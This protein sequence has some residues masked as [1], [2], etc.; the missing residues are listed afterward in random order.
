MKKVL[1]LV[2][3]KYHP[4]LSCGE[5]LKRSL[6][7]TG[8]FKVE[9]TEDNGRL[10]E[11]SG[12]DA[13]ALY[14]AFGELARDTEKAFLAYVRSGGGVLA[15]HGA[16]YSFLESPGYVEMIGTQFTGHGPV[17]AFDVELAPDAGSI[18]TRVSPRFPVVDEFYQIDRR[19][20]ARLRPMLYGWWQFEKK[21][22]GY[23]RDYGKGRVF[24][25]ALGHDERVFRHA[26]FQNLL[27]KGLRYVTRQKERTVRVG[28]LGYGPAFKMGQHH[29]SQIAA[30]PGLTLTAVCDRDPARL[31][32][33]REEQGKGIATFR[34]A[35]AM[36]ASGKVD[37]GVVILP[38][39][40][41]FEGAKTLLEA[42]LHVITEKPFAVHVSE[43]EAL[44]GLARKRGV[45]LSVYHNR[46]WDPEIRT[47]AEVISSGAIGQ[48]FSI[49]CQMCGFGRPGQAWRSHK[50]IS[51]G[52]AYD[53]GAHQFEKI[54]QLV[55]WTD[56]SGK[57]INR[58]AF[59][60]GHFLKKRW[61]DTTN[62][63]FVRAY[64]RFDSGLEAQLLVSSLCAS[65]KPLWCLLGTQGSITVESWQ[66]PVKV[67]ARA[68][69]GRIVVTET[70]QLPGV[71]GEYYRNVADHLLC[72]T[73]L[74]ITPE[75][76]K[77]P[78]QCIEGCEQAARENRLVEVQFH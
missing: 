70:P 60:Y 16:N 25:T 14:T 11:L 59:L 78:I 8:Q 53:M 32:A 6:E 38:H 48:L 19:T 56:A 42:G 13:V 15:I 21:L 9:L 37:L 72:G 77:R 33:A 41:H 5:I 20:R 28:L 65:P 30:T 61:H 35:R 17:S 66:S 34:D 29:S 57:P 58:R 71:S 40:Y 3:G 36:A 10:G 62:E 24:Y 44:M 27:Y 75:V 2:G 69:D 73:P 74:I 4:F 76:G 46:H 51:G 55:P 50:P 22:L 64:V 45:M 63:D 31:K 49:E 18:L 47:I 54:F 23:V 39:A 68:E 1:L 43:C 7:G 26:E 12:V 67:H 52:A